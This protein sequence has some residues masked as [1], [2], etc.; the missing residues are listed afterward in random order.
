MSQIKIFTWCA[1][2]QGSFFFSCCSLIVLA[3]FWKDFPLLVNC[4]DVDLFLVP[5]F[6]SKDALSLWNILMP[7][8]FF[9]VVLSIVIIN[10][11]SNFLVNLLPYWTSLCKWCVKDVLS[12]VIY[13]K[14]KEIGEQE[15]CDVQIS[16]RESVASAS[17]HC[18]LWIMNYSTQDV[19]LRGE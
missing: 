9:A 14:S 19:L 15:E 4:F 3:H 8:F 11:C 2:S 5:L 18:G 6:C 17:F 16:F 10:S 1:R 12:V 7:F 13:K